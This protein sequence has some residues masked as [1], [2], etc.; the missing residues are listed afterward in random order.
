MRS[1]VRQISEI[2]PLGH[3]SAPPIARASVTRLCMQKLRLSTS[4]REHVLAAFEACCAALRSAELAARLLDAEDDK[5]AERSAQLREAIGQLRGTIAELRLVEEEAPSL[6]ATGLILPAPPDRPAQPQP[7]RP[8]P[9]SG[10]T[11]PSGPC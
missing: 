5:G 4:E 9:P 7:E 2:V 8:P 6:L 11:I 1:E 10:A 3:V